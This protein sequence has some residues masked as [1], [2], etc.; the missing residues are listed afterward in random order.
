MEGSVYRVLAYS[1]SNLVLGTKLINYEST[2]CVVVVGLD[3]FLEL[4][5][6]SV[7]FGWESG[8]V[9]IG[10]DDFHFLLEFVF[11]LLLSFQGV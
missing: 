10:V 6:L 8:V 2:D 9:V 5:F 4:L 7:E 1:S 3:L 11:F